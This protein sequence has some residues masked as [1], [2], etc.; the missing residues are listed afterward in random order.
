MPQAFETFIIPQTAYVI[1]EGRTFT[2]LSLSLSL[3]L[4]VSVFVD[5]G[6]ASLAI[7]IACE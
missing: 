6:S 7:R 2:H 4:S 1:E 3:F 5:G